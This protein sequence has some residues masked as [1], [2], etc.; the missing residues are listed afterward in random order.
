MKTKIEGPTF[1]EKYLL[2]SII[3]ITSKGKKFFQ[4]NKKIAELL[5][6]SQNSVSTMISKLIKTGYLVKTNQD[7]NRYLEYTGKEFKQ[8]PVFINYKSMESA[9]IE[10][11]NKKLKQENAKLL[12][13]I[14]KLKNKEAL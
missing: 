9:A 10:R 14:E 1:Y 11:E 7:G 5:D 6:I 13:E 8:I 4:S 3:N 12:L 2:A